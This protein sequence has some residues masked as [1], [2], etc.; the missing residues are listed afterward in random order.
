MPRSIWTGSLSFG[1][2][3]I[4]VRLFSATEQKDVAFHQFEEGTGR[5]IHLKRVAEGTDDEV[6]YDKVVKGYEV[7][8]GTWVTLTPE[9]VAA[10]DPEGTRTIDI[11]QFVDL[12]EI[13]PVQ[14][15]KSYYLAPED[16]QG[17]ARKAYRLLQKALTDTGRVAIGRFVMRDKQYLAT[18][19]TRGDVLVLETMFFPDEVRDPAEVTGVTKGGAVDRKELSMARHLVDALSAPWEPDRYHDTHR[20][21]LLAI[22]HRKAKG[23]TIEV[24]STERA[25]APV[26]DLMAALQ[27]SVDA[28]R[29]GRKNARGRTR[30]ASASTGRG[31]TANGRRASG[32]Q[33]GA[34]PAGGTR[35]DTRLT[36]L[37]KEQLLDQAKRAGVKGRSKMSRDELV[38]ALA[39]A[40]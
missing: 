31:K 19:R 5:R 37:S 13:D 24:P 29:G 33:A 34:S 16:G 6:P 10:A 9:E 4:P 27:A 18:I 23:E 32:K 25:S 20:E 30:E 8:S 21:D 36:K 28:A 11:E 38:G 22:I 15:E 12:A 7:S 40:G 39:K 35:A 26:V 17:G 1:L 14:Y 2:V 3:N